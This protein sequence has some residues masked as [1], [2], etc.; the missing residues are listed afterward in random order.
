MPSSL[1]KT[2]S[3]NFSPMPWFTIISRANS[4][5]CC[6]SLPAPV[7]GQHVVEL[8]QGHEHAVFRR[9]EPGIAAGAAAWNN[10]HFVHR[11]AVRQDVTDE[12]VA[13]FVVSRGDFVGF[14]HDLALAL[15][16][17][18]YALKSFGDICRCDLVV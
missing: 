16:T 13:S 17:D 3:R 11:I 15:R 4:A 6:K 7:A 12:G 8:D 9:N 14:G 5:A 2:W 10:R 18:S 1:L